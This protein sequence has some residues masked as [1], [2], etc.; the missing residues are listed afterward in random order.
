MVDFRS[1]TGVLQEYFIQNAAAAAHASKL[2]IDTC[3]VSVAYVELVPSFQAETRCLNWG[4]AGIQT[5]LAMCVTQQGQ[6][7]NAP[8][9]P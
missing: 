4:A 3:R 6:H 5:R 8:E 9:V 1:A 7:Y 2:P